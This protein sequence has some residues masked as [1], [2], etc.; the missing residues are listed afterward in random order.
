VRSA[1]EAVRDALADFSLEYLRGVGVVIGEADLPMGLESVPYR[2][3]MVR[4]FSESLLG[5][6]LVLWLAWRRVQLGCSRCFRWCSLLRS[7]WGRF[8]SSG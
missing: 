2:D 6:F 5:S 1:S 8:R 3:T 7:G 4:S